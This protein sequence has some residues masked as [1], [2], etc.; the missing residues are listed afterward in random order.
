MCIFNDSLG[1]Q[2]LQKTDSSLRKMICFILKELIILHEDITDGEEIALLEKRPSNNLCPWHRT[3]SDRNSFVGCS[4]LME[5]K[6]VGM[7]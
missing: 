6:L 1:P 4:L 7:R 2:T 3:V 5:P